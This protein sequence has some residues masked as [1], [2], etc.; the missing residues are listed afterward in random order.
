MTT[1]RLFDLDDTTRKWMMEE[2]RHDLDKGALF[3]SPLL[4]DRGRREYPDLL[5]EAIG[6]H[7]EAWLASALGS[8]DRMN[9]TQKSVHQG[10]GEHHK[11]A[12]RA[13]H[14]NPKAG[15]PADD[16]AQEVPTSTPQVLA[17]G[18][19]NRYYARGLCRRAIDE[20]V[21]A[22]EIYRYSRA[23]GVHF[24]DQSLGEPSEPGIDRTGG[25]TVDP[26]ELLARLRNTPEEE[27]DTGV[28]GEPN[29][30][31]SVRLPEARR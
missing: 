30:G 16:A 5:K 28:P 17:E 11:L 7:D 23:A 21:D 4:S 27:M 8:G 22:L 14:S 10:S 13:G 3:V 31:L 18:V 24:T 1:H 19:F 15:I 25:T 26:K 29:S 12:F 20:G 9:L 6:R 2:Y